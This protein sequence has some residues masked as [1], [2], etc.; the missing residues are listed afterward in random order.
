MDILNFIV[1]NQ[2]V[3]QFSVTHENYYIDIVIYIIVKSTI[4]LKI[5]MLR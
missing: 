4:C 3:F 2:F 1:Y 5:T